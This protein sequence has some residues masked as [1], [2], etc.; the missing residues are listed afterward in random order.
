MC[1]DRAEF[2]RKSSEACSSTMFE[3]CLLIASS[4]FMLFFFGVLLLLLLLRFVF[5]SFCAYLH[6]FSFFFLISLSY[7]FYF[8]FFFFFGLFKNS[9]RMVI[10]VIE[11]RLQSRAESFNRQFPNNDISNFLLLVSRETL[12]WMFHFAHSKIAIRVV[13][14]YVHLLYVHIRVHI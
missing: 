7:I 12:R 14:C 6:F 1:K 11:F 10:R 3:S 4:F 5:V 9:S 2:D 13:M 8:S